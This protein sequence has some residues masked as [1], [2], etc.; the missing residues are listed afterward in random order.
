MMELDRSGYYWQGDRI[1]LR[2]MHREDAALWLEED[3]DSDAVR[4]LHYGMDVPKSTRAAEEFADRFAD[5]NGREER[6]M[7]SIETLDGELV[8]GSTST[9]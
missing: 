1:R 3:A 7:F 6:I 4:F 2:P 8:G 9:P 5:F